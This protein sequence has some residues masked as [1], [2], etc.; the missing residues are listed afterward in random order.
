MNGYVLN[1]G[2]LTFVVTV[3]N[4]VMA[5]F[6]ALIFTWTIMSFLRFRRL[7]KS[8]PAIRA[9]MMDV[10]RMIEKYRSLF[11]IEIIE[12]KGVTFKRGMHVKITLAD[13]KSFVG[14][15]VGGNESNRVCIITPKSIITPELGIIEELIPLENGETI[16]L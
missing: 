15:F 2:G 5:A 7:V 9:Q 11:P 12:Y 16:T 1:I 10:K 6:L 8:M 13:K 14:S 3:Q 4:I